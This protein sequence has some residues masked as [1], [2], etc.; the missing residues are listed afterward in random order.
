MDHLKIE[1]KSQV[2]QLDLSDGPEMLT[3]FSRE[4]QRHLISARNALLVLETV[5]S[6]KEALENI[7]KTF[8]T[9]SGLAEFLNLQDICLLSKHAET[10]INFV[11]K[12]ERFFED[13][14]AGLIADSV[15][16]IQRLLELLDE[17]I[18]HEGKLV[19]DY[20]D[21]E[22]LIH[23]IRRVCDGHLPG[24][25]PASK[26]RPVERVAQPLAL[27]PETPTYTIIKQ[28]FDE[29]GGKGAF[30]LETSTVSHLMSEFEMLEGKLKDAQ[31]KIQERQHELIRER[32]LALK[33]TKKAQDEARAKSEYLANMSHEIR[34][35]INAILGFTDLIK[36]KLPEGSKQRDH[37]NTI[38]LSGKML[39]E[40]V[41]NILDF[42]KVEAGK[43]KL[44]TIPFNLKSIAQ[45]VFQI[46]RTRLDRKPINL[47]LEMDPNVPTDLIGDPTR[48]KQVF[49]NLLDNAIKFTD[50]GEIGIFI[51]YEQRKNDLYTLRFRVSDTGIG[52]PDDRKEQV[53]ETF[54]QADVSTTRLYGGSGLGLALCRAFVVAMGGKIWV[55]SQL[56]KGSNF[57]FDLAF[58]TAPER[59]QAEPVTD[60]AGLRVVAVSSQEMTIRAM[61]R[62]CV[63]T[64]VQLVAICQNPKQATEYL[65]VSSSMPDIA[66]IDML[67]HPEA[68]YELFKK[69]RSQTSTK[70]ISLVAVSSDV[71]L[72]DDA[73]FR[74]AGF[75]G[76]LATPLFLDEFAPTVRQATGRRMKVSAE[77]AGPGYDDAFFKGIRILVVEDSIPNQ[78]LL[79][80]HFDT[81]GCICDYASNGQEA[82][83]LLKQKTFQIC[84]MDL[85]MPV[86]GGLEASQIIRQ[87]LKLDLPII[88]L[89]AAEV[90]EEREKCLAVGMSDYLPKPFDVDQLKDKIHKFLK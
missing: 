81:L 84:F 72:S 71:K 4:A 59:T 43:L 56:G 69:L 74:S 21:I 47:F 37:L 13:P 76:L 28:K 36:G 14:I 38:I 12:G 79:R 82:L 18:E 32:E 9:I 68:G 48:L 17:Q 67:P 65:N 70:N 58:K 86:L 53:F 30:F 1:F 54:T 78:E 26:P 83:D 66:F 35:L 61:Q 63:E 5:H 52:I 8:H 50:K 3:D 55:E 42:S 85:Q 49:M 87:D 25:V 29:S 23:Q 62:L 6:D 22:E 41:N 57:Y 90:Q 39:L 73:K 7:F 2:P 89:T 33:L 77:D 64:G 11:R 88:A 75:N 44:E 27:D 60:L 40:I 15:K 45:E 16:G 10:L 19:S 24:S 20:F 51:R 46:I 31:S 80:V 34:T